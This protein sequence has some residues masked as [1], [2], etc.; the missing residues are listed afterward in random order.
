MELVPLEKLEM[1]A[2]SRVVV[3]SL[4]AQPS[5]EVTAARMEGL[6]A[7]KVDSSNDVDELKK[8]IE[9][10]YAATSESCIAACVWVMPDTEELLAAPLVVWNHQIRRFETDLDTYS[11]LTLC[12]MSDGVPK[13]SHIVEDAC[14]TQLGLAVQKLGQL[15]EAI[16]SPES[17]N[18]KLH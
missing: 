15:H 16:K 3:F 17:I 14:R 9:S 18:T 6:V 1:A 4:A 8:F 11:T 10:K 5:G 2:T 13:L 12:A 7:R